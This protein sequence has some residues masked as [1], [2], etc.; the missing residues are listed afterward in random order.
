MSA[1][2]KGASCKFAAHVADENHEYGTISEP[3]QLLRTAMPANKYKNIT[4]AAE[5]ARI[6]CLFAPGKFSRET[7]LL[8]D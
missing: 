6:S 2:A 1:S 5:A 4:Y 3:R 7:S 8:G